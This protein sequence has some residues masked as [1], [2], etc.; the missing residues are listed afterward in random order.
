M[1]II[2]TSDHFKKKKKEEKKITYILQV[3]E[4]KMYKTKFSQINTHIQP[5]MWQ[6]L[7]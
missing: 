5:T 6:Y 3:E 7:Y 1:K 4:K 2:K